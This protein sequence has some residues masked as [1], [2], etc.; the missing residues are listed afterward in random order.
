[1]TYYLKELETHCKG[2][3]QHI[4]SLQGAIQFFI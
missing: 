3:R 2:F 1:M 4:G